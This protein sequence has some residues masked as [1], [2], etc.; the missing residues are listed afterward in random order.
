VL[1]NSEGLYNV[2][3]RV[4]AVSRCQVQA[5]GS[6]PKGGGVGLKSDLLGRKLLMSFPGRP[7]VA[8]VSKSHA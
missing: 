4:L 6:S 8:D 3:D 2:V 7:V 5:E 1:L